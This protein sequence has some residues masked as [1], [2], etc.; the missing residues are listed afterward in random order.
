MLDTLMKVL[1]YVLFPVGAMIV[2]GI[3]ATFRT[4]GRRLGSAIQHFAAGMVFAAVAIELLPDVVS[5]RAPLATIF[6]F[7]LG[8]A[9]M[10][11]VSWL[12]KR[13]ESAGQNKAKEK[14]DLSASAG[15]GITE[16]K[17]NGST[18]LIAAV[19][20]DITIDG[21]LIGIAFAA[22][23]KQGILLTVA[24]TLELLSL[25]LATVTALHQ[26]G[27]SSAR[28]IAT[29]TALAVLILIG[30]TVGVTLLAGLAGPALV[31]VLAFGV[32]ALLYLVTEE[33]LVEAHEVPETA[34]VTSIFFVG[35]LLL[36]VIALLV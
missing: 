12:S 29:N 6:G 20:V 35:F 14:R 21:F 33:L 23:A 9:L 16:N 1:L 34:L 36:L 31:A 4:P 5:K 11:L 30:A 8:V 27:A 2:G 10:L 32:A 22:S 18:G 19:G 17:G 15:A 25:G 3:I 26:T 28:S 7:S 24:L 13:A